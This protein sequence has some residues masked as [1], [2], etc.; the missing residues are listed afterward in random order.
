MK[1]YIFKTTMVILALIISLVMTFAVAATS[2][3]ANTIYACANSK[4]GLLRVVSSPTD[5]TSREASI[6]WNNQVV[7]SGTIKQDGTI[8]LGSGFTV[9]RDREG[10]NTI[11]FTSPFSDIPVCAITADTASSGDR[12]ACNWGGLDSFGMIVVCTTLIYQIDPDTNNYEISEANSKYAD[13]PFTF[14]CVQ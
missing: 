10:F 13:I 14:I 1:Q 8:L 4:S 5:C 7:V 3:A 2:E 9:T 6:S 11:T 12:P